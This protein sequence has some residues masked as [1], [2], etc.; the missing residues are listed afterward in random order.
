MR[1][2]FLGDHHA[3][4]NPKWRQQEHG[5]NQKYGRYLEHSCSGSF[6]APTGRG[7][8]DAVTLGTIFDE[9]FLN[10]KVSDLL[11][12]KLY[13]EDWSP[14]RLYSLDQMQVLS[15]AI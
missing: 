7:H 5:H 3:I 4:I 6:S 13:F 12:K 10:Q 15:W 14:A 9:G 2:R 11:R 8:R 1:P